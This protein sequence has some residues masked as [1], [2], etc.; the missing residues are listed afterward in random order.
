MT[1]SL[2]FLPAPTSKPTHLADLPIFRFSQIGSALA[3][4]GAPVGTVHSFQSKRPAATS[5][6]ATLSALETPSPR[7][8]PTN[9]QESRAHPPTPV[10]GAPDQRSIHPPTRPP[11]TR[12]KG[13]WG[14]TWILNPLSS[15]HNPVRTYLDFEPRNSHDTNPGIASPSIPINRPRQI[16]T[17]PVTSAAR[18]CSHA[19][20]APS[21]SARGPSPSHP[22]RLIHSCT[23]TGHNSIPSEPR[24]T[25]PT[26]RLSPVVA[27]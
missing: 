3:S 16:S 24:V 1:D 10:A 19:S 13:H 14:P 15:R 5:K 8:D 7:S 20:L 23:S 4:P 27:A 25:I 22:R 17:A 9:E 2:P 12:K 21:T 26:S 18:S 6:V 11:V